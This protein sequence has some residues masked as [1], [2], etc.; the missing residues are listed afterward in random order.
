MAGVV[1]ERMA[2]CEGAQMSGH[3]RGHGHHGHQRGKRGLTWTSE[4][5]EGVKISMP[6]PGTILGESGLLTPHGGGEFYK[7]ECIF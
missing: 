1:D 6:S 7:I 3:Q 4:R 2:I 5:E